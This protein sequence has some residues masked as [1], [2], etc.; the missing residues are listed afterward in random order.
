MRLTTNETHGIDTFGNLLV[1]VLENIRLRPWLVGCL[2]LIDGTSALA[3]LGSTP[4]PQASNAGARAPKSAKVAIAPPSS[5]QPYT[6][7]VITD[8]SGGVTHEY[9]NTQGVVFAVRWSGPVL[10]NFQ[11]LF[12]NHFSA[13]QTEAERSRAARKRGAPLSLESDTLVMVSRGKMGHFTGYAYVPS[14]V[15]AGVDID[16]LLQ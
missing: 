13:L 2:M 14:L 11:A 10:P 16:D 4:L 9:V 6:D 8:A 15:P 5:P 12:G 7:S 1:T 3:A